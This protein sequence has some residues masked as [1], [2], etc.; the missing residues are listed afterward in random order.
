MNIKGNLNIQ[1]ESMSADK[2][3][4]WYFYDLRKF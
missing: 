3:V 2:I 4:N 1:A